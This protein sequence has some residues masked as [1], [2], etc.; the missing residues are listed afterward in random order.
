[1]IDII[2][3]VFAIVLFG[4][5][6][7]S[8]YLMLYTWEHPDRLEK[9]AGPRSFLPAQHT[10]TVLLPARH[11]EAVI[12]ETIRRVWQANYPTNM[13]EVVVICHSD[14]HGTIAEAQRAVRA[15]GS[16]RVRVETFS[17]LPINKPHGLN[18]GLQRTS[19]GVVT[20]FDA[21]DDID[22]DIFNVVNT[23]MLEEAVGIVQSGV[24]LMNFRDH[25]FSSHNCL[26]YF[27][28]F[29]SRLHFHAD[30]G[31]IPLGGNT[32]FFR[33]DLLEK[34][35][36]WD[37]NCLT[38]DADVGLRLSALGEPIRVVYDAQHVT[39]E[40]TPDS[41]GAFIKQ[42]TRWLQGFLQV[43]RKGDW[44]GLP[45]FSQR[46][47]ALYTL[48]YPL[49]QG[50]L[51]LLWP[52]TVLMILLLKVHVIVAIVSFLPLY[53]LLLQLLAVTV[54]M[55]L[56]TREYGY[57][58][59]LLMPLKMAVT[60]VPFQA[61]MGI[62][63]IRAV[64][65][66][67]R[68]M[69][70]WEKT[71]HVGAHRVPSTAGTYDWV[72]DQAANRLG[73][74]RGS[75]MLLEEVDGLYSIHA[76]RGLP[77]TVKTSA[78]IAPGEGVAGWVAQ[79]R[80]PVVINGKPLPADLAPRLRQPELMSSIVVPFVRDGTTVAM[81]CVSSETQDLNEDHISWLVDRFTP[82]LASDPDVMDESDFSPVHVPLAGP[83]L[84]HTTS[85]T[86]SAKTAAGSTR[87]VLIA[88]VVSLTI[89]FTNEAS[90]VFKRG[91]GVPD[92]EAVRQVVSQ[93]TLPR[94]ERDVQPVF[95]SPEIQ[96]RDVQP[97]TPA[98]LR[99]NETVPL[100]PSIG[101]GFVEGSVVHDGLDEA[102]IGA[103]QLAV[104]NMAF[105]RFQEIR[106]GNVLVGQPA[107]GSIEA[108]RDESRTVY[109]G[110]Y[111]NGF[112][113]EYHP[114]HAGTEYE[115]MLG[116]LGVAEAQNRGL[117]DTPAFLPLAD[118]TGSDANCGFFLETG[119]RLC[120]G[121]RDHWA[122]NG[123]ELGDSGVSFRESLALF[124]Y[125]ISE[126]FV[127]PETG[128]LV[129]YFERTR[130]EY[131]PNKPEGERVHLGDIG[132]DAVRRDDE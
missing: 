23:V 109:L 40:E 79:H 52:M 123:L 75:V 13:L 47:L 102:V 3:A 35:G 76:A 94:F 66:E 120:N 62:S 119:H 31:M 7:F 2:I 60:F 59:P 33:R 125:P 25:W 93:N 28:W 98:V 64:Y 124:G 127:D 131:D 122:S 53:A 80:K 38:E 17:E 21:E 57:R 14:D 96:Q 63:A 67:A 48:S 27:F 39:R 29:K 34:V 90:G 85:A 18:V 128:K 58:M 19:N 15:I 51:V 99:P 8:L 110:T 106:S 43:L 112:R 130:F 69:N 121:F 45:T 77:E 5:A 104:L 61:L 37:D 16:R 30:V 74:E 103:E 78:R 73:A 114:E 91:G 11:E 118:D 65:R 54:G 92:T 44:L 82:V 32:V 68:R 117:L 116:R 50:L 22:P 101:G 12:Y 100:N 107:E 56:F 81:L 113:L 55:F 97:V 26:E 84:A 95:E 24:Q 83:P 6:M 20:V 88:L 115:V 108:V 111:I 1:M 9:S 105:E 129:Q 89:I 41:V 36:G 72:L 70:N 86:K 10:F 49:V 132:I 42:R 126:E 87:I 46:L 71:D 4:Q